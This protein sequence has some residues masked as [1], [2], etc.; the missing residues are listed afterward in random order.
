MP[1]RSEK[2]ENTLGPSMRYVFDFGKPDYL[3]FILPTGESGNFISGH[4]K[5]MTKKW[6]KGEYIHL[7]LN[8]EEFIKNAKDELKL[9]PQ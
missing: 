5:D 2:Y 9:I 1:Q 4:Y 7:P 8:E 3:D 6:L